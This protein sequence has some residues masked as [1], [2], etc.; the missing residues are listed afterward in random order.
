MLA[1]QAYGT[2]NN[3]NKIQF[4]KSVSIFIY[5]TFYSKLIGYYDT[6]HY[7]YHYKKKNPYVSMKSYPF[8]VQHYYIC[9]LSG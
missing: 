7:W 2:I 3:E 5:N 4:K 8:I 9:F 6:V 1:A